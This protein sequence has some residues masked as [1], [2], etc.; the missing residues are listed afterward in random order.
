MKRKFF[1]SLIFI[2]IMFCLITINS[3]FATENKK[4][5]AYEL[6]LNNVTTVTFYRST[7]DSTMWYK[8]TAPENDYYEFEAINP[9]YD[10]VYG[11]YET[12]MNVYNSNGTTLDY[13]YTDEFTEKCIGY[14]ECNAGQTYYIEVNNFAD[15]NYNLNMTVRKHTHQY[16]EEFILEA[17]VYNFNSYDSGYVEYQCKKCDHRY[18]QIIPAV[19]EIRL[20]NTEFVYDGTKKVPVVTVTD[21]QG[22]VLSSDIYTVSSFYDTS[23][24]KDSVGKYYI[25]VE[26]NG[27]YYKG[28]TY[29]IPYAIIPKGTSISKVRANKKGFN[30]KWKKQSTETTG[31]EVQYSTSR[32]F[33]SA[34]TI[35]ISKNKIISTNVKKLKSKKKYYIRVRTYKTV[36]GIKYYSSWSK[37]KN[38]KTK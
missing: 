26:F 36:N 24:K 22:N 18:K 10:S 1:I 19:S 35:N 13:A 33:K 3:S 8:F 37:V 9:Y 5:T 27:R 4:S 7:Y 29:Y 15:Y 21:T 2:I 31:Y 17:Y 30:I 25:T 14:A 34:K 12:S 23:H 28:S 20:S 38:V 32:N 6:T 16:D 11:E